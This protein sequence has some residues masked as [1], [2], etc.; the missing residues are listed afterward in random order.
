MK[1]NVIEYPWVGAY[2][3]VPIRASH[4]KII[5]FPRPMRR[6]LPVDARLQMAKDL[7]ERQ[8]QDAMSTA[9][10]GRPLSE[11]PK[12][13]AIDERLVDRLVAKLAEMWP[14]DYENAK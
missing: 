6:D 8:I 4:A 1:T 13:S 14:E 9:W 7:R 10:A 2:N 12:K 5:P 11:D 3:R